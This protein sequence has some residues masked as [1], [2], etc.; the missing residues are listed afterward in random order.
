MQKMKYKIFNTVKIFD[1]NIIKKTQN[2]LTPFYIDFTFFVKIA[3]VAQTVQVAQ[4]APSHPHELQ[5]PRR[6]RMHIRLHRWAA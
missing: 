2:S 3:Q 4:V 1:N 5:P 6:H